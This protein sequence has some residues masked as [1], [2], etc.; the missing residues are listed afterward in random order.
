MIDGLLVCQTV[1]LVFS[2]MGVS[3]FAGKFFYCFNETSEEIMLADEVNNKSQCYYLILENYTEIRWKNMK[4]NFDNTAMGFLSLLL[5][6]SVITQN[7]HR[8]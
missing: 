2:I 6:V 5:L 3:T 8:K 4:F 1:W 7:T